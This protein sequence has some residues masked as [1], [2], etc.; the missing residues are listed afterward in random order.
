ME[1]AED[2]LRGSFVL[3]TLVQD[4]EDIP[5]LIHRMPEGMRLPVEL[6]ELFLDVSC[7]SGARR[8]WRNRFASVWSVLRHRSPIVS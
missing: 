6:E 4:V 1:R 8:R 7:V 5:S 3:P 2:L